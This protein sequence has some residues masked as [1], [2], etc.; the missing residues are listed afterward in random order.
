MERFVTDHFCDLRLPGSYIDARS[1]R[2]LQE[3]TGLLAGSNLRIAERGTLPNIGREANSASYL[4]LG[5][6]FSGI[7]HEPRL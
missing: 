3:L 6:V 5:Q 1:C 2:H 4:Q 7:L